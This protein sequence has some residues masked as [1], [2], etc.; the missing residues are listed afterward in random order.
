MTD[1]EIVEMFFRRDEEAVRLTHE[2]YGSYCC[3]IAFGI[4]RSREDA[5]ECENDACAAAWNA[6]PP[7][8]PEVLKTFMGKLVRRISLKRLR[9]RMAIKR[10]G[11]TSAAAALEEL[12]EC[13]PSGYSI[14][15]KTDSA[16]IVRV[17]N[18]FLASLSD[19]ERRI[20]VCRYWYLDSIASI[21]VRFGF[22]H[23]KVKM[24][25]KR[26]RDRLRSVL[27]KEDII[28]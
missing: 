21:A 25:L 7:S 27:E 10:G 23:S 5:Q 16:E 19:D 12:E 3:S 22:G 20:F 11:G 9:G 26:T 1:S 15:E 24:T 8:R 2:R 28:I 14:D 13:V 4:L 17:I 18:D 6:I